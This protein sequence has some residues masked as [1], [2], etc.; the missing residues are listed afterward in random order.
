MMNSWE[1]WKV[2]D[3]ESPD[4]NFPAEFLQQFGY[5]FSFDQKTWIDFV[6]KQTNFSIFGQGDPYISLSPINVPI[7]TPA[8]DFCTD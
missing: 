5:E 7:P 8:S 3:G 4:I 6:Q 2:E 1:S